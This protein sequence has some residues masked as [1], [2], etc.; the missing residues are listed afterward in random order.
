MT[1]RQGVGDALQW[2]RHVDRFAGHEGRRV[3]VALAWWHRLNTP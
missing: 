3:L 1:R 2:D